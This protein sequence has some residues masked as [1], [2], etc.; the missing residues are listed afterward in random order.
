M[1]FLYVAANTKKSIQNYPVIKRNKYMGY[2]GCHTVEEGK[3]KVTE[4]GHTQVK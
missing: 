3:C 2:N 4:D 1:F